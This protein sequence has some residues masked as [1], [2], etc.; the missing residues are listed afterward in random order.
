VV[1]AGNRLHSSVVLPRPVLWTDPLRLQQVLLNLL[2]NANKFTQSGDIT[3]GAHELHDR[4]AHWIVFD[5]SDTGIGIAADKLDAVFEAFTQA[6][7]ET[8]RRFGGTGL[9]LTISRRLCEML[10]GT[11]GVTS[12]PGRGSTFTVRLPWRAP[13]AQPGRT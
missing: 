10:G 5:V 3:L 7:N 4:G 11:I 6:D 12:E 1:A 8:T 13:P 2:G 9:G